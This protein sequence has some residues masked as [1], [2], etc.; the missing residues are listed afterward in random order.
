MLK[1][2]FELVMLTI[3]PRASSAAS[4]GSALLLPAGVTLAVNF[5]VIMLKT[6]FT[7]FAGSLPRTVTSAALTFPLVTVVNVPLRKTGAG[8]PVNSSE[9][10]TVVTG[11][12]L[13]FCVLPAVMP[14]EGIIEYR[15]DCP[16]ISATNIKGGVMPVTGMLKVPSE[17]DVPVAVLPA[18]SLI[19]TLAPTTGAP[20]ATVPVTVTAVAV[21]LVPPDD[22]EETPEAP[23][24]P[25][26][27]IRATAATNR[28]DVQNLFVMLLEK[29]L[30]T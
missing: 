2:T 1:V 18:L 29:K 4:Y 28:N 5:P 30:S 13:I 14:I 12:I 26:P 23:P 11:V 21:V 8:S 24:P 27:E 3:L 19:V 22:D 16:A 7:L 9:T 15:L 6:A 17:P 10:T 25:Q 20:V